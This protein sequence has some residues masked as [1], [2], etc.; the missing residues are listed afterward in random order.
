MGCGGPSDPAAFPTGSG[1][2]DDD[3]SGDDDD[4]TPADPDTDQD[5]YPASVDCDDS[6]F[7]VWPGAPEL[8]DEV[9]NDC[10]DEVDEAPLADIAWYPDADDDGY[11]TEAGVIYGCEPLPG[12]STVPGDCD[13][14]NPAIHPGALIDG[15]DADCDGRTEWR[16]RILIS[17]VES[18][19]LCVDDENNILGTDTLWEDAETWDVWLDSGLHTIGFRGVG[20]S[21][22]SKQKL[23]G[24]MLD[25]SISDGT[26]WWTNSN[27]RYDP[28][29]EAI[30][31][32]REG[33]CSPGFDDADWGIARDFG[34]WGVPPWGPLPVELEDSAA[35]WIWDDSPVDHA[36]QYFRLDIEL[37]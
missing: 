27:W 21:T 6:N 5:G 37:P 1:I 11:G 31:T 8:C 23:T 10:D 15:Y 30:S 32:S 12:T 13:D 14:N 20:G 4:A 24:A 16:V 29:P 19:R 18:Y 3:S 26:S 35:S 34:S 25:I 22:P 36:T 2:D 7:Y 33:W 28:S 17:V 9:D